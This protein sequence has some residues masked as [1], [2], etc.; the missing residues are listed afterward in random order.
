MVEKTGVLN[1]SS[2]Y[3]S[4][5]EVNFSVNGDGHHLDVGKGQYKWRRRV[6]KA[7]PHKL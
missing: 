3:F 2:L 6:I 1:N 5:N 7:K 4:C